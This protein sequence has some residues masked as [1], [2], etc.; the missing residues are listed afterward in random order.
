MPQCFLRVRKVPKTLR[1]NVTI[2]RPANSFFTALYLILLKLQ[3]LA[4][5]GVDNIFLFKMIFVTLL[6]VQKDLL[7]LNGKVQRKSARD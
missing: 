1:S 4:R 7:S 2:T 6:K 5:L 3:H